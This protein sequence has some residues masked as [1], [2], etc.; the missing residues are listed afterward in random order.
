MQKDPIAARFITSMVGA[1][2]VITSLTSHASVIFPQAG[3]Q[4]TL[5]MDFHMVSG[6]VTAVDA[7]TIMIENFKYDGEG[8]DVYFYLGSEESTSAFIEGLEIGPQLLGSVFDGAG[9]PLIIDLPAGQT[10]EGY[11]AISVWC[12]TAGVSFGSGT[13]APV[14]EPSVF[15]L[16]AFA[17]ISLLRRR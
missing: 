12:T 15:G 4:A 8:I 16:S 5:S 9:A 11:G 14:P 13:F 7:D 10:L 17:A 6:L 3:D 2:F 1:A